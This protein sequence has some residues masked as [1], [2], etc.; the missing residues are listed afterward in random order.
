MDRLQ[1]SRLRVPGILE[2]A[3]LAVLVVGAGVVGLTMAVL[4][5]SQ[6]YVLYETNFIDRQ[7]G[8]DG[9]RSCG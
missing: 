5:A 1:G 7:S 2:R 4:L 3:N 9:L 8:R 6:G